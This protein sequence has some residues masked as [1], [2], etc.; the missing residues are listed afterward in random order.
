MLLLRDWPGVASW[1]APPASPSEIPRLWQRNA[2]VLHVAA[3]RGAVPECFG[4]GVALVATGP[5][6]LCGCLVV[7]D[8]LAETDPP[9]WPASSAGRKTTRSA[10]RRPP[11]TWQRARRSSTRAPPSRRNRGRSSPTPTAAPGSSSAPISGARS[12]SAPST[13]ADAGATELGLGNC[14]SRDGVNSTT[15]HGSGRA[16]TA[17]RCG[18]SARRVGWRMEFGPCE[19]ERTA[20]RRARCTGAGYGEG[21]SSTS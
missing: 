14:G 13:A 21:R 17:R 16:R 18:V 6:V 10:T 8:D 9:P 15:A 11:G 1:T 3:R 4:L 20:N 2:L 12:G 19:R 5:S 7:P